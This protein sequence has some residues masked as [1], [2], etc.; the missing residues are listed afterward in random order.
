[1]KCISCGRES[2]LI[3]KNLRLCKE[4]IVRNEELPLE[5][6]A[7]SIMRTRFSLPSRPPSDGKPCGRCINSCRM[8]EGE[9][10]Y[11]GI[12]ENRNG[13][14]HCITGDDAIADVYCDPLPTNCV[15][16]W[17]CPGCTKIGFPR[18]SF[19]NGPEYG[20]KNLAVFYG[21][22]SFDCLFCQ[23]WQYRFMTHSKS[24]VMSVAQLASTIDNET[25][26]I[27]YFGGDPT[28]F[29][30]HSIRLSKKILSDLDRILRLCWETNGSMARKYAK[31]IGK[32]ALDSGGCVKIDLKAWNERLHKILCGASNDWAIK[33]IE[34]LAD[35]GLSRKEVPLLIVSTLLIPGYIDEFEIAAIA[36]FLADL[37]PDIPYSLLAFQPQYM[38][39]DL[40]S[41]SMEQAK[42]CMKAARDAGLKNVN[43]GNPWLLI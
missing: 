3:S 16:S 26:C 33:N 22:C 8:K 1:M 38:M 21:A 29:I 39:L 36:S 7:R 30:D 23:N 42:K 19:V 27:C 31:D 4:C 12:W 28:P 34:L 18:Y 2:S 11:C 15:A 20:Y 41:T 24:P 32:L 14:I 17:T 6:P 9:R 5:V 25:S 35:I 43:L 13:H 10:G 37:D 40:P